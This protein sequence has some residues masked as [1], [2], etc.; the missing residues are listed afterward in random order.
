MTIARP[1]TQGLLPLD[2][3]IEQ[4]EGSAFTRALAAPFRWMR[5]YPTLWAGL[6][7]LAF[8]ILFGI[9]GSQFVDPELARAGT[10]EIDL[11]P[12]QTV[13]YRVKGEDRSAF[14][15]LGT[16]SQG[17]DVWAV[18]MLGTPLTIYV[19]FLAALI[20][21]AIGTVLGFIGGFYGGIIDNFFK[22]FA[23]MLI[24]VPVLMIL[25][26]VAVTLKS[27]IDVTQQA[28]II[29]AF[30]WMWPLRTIRAQVLTMRERAYI[31]VAQISGANTLEVI[32]LEMLPN[33]LPFLAASL[34]TAVAT[35]M[36]TTIGMDALGLGPQNQPTLGNTI[37]WA[38]FYS[39]P[40]RGIWWWWT[41]PVIALALVFGS[42]YLITAGLDPLANPRLR[43]QG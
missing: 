36:L 14:S 18:T 12:G 29:S 9:V 8:M 35:A 31:S 19:G 17:R 39:A 16:D 38:L 7:L 43:R 41:P 37:Y 20:G 26:V 27:S 1:E 2:T 10:V 5:A 4:Q 13:E 22:S 42:L 21:M 3:T 40:F 34:A 28:L 25:V 24:T 15:V 23:D 6:F 11:S 32:F 30:V 33:L